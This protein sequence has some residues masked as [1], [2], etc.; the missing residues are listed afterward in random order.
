MTTNI[1]D[2]PGTASGFNPAE[3]VNSIYFTFSA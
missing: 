2:A 1:V 3:L